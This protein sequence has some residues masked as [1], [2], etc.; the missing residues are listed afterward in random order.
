MDDKTKV[1]WDRRQYHGMRSVACHSEVILTG[2][3]GMLPA[4]ERPRQGE[5]TSNRLKSPLMSRGR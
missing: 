4:S 2:I 3:H 5:R 1:N